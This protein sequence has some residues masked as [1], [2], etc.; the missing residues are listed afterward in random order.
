MTDDKK[1]EGKKPIKKKA[2]KKDDSVS[3][4]AD[5]LAKLN[6]ELDDILGED[7]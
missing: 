1:V 2:V 5:R 4:E 3:D 7:L 6:Q